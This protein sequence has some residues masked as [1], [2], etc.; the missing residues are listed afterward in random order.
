[1]VISLDVG[2][3]YEQEG[4]GC[5]QR[6][7][8]PGAIKE[9]QISRCRDPRKPEAGPWCY[10]VTEANCRSSR[11]SATLGVVVSPRSR[12]ATLQAATMAAPAA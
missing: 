9:R 5:N 2:V 7:A 8:K 3:I 1:V 11:S 10:W 4:A 12:M 6:K